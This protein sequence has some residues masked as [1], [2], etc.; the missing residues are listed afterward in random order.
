MPA[1]GSLNAD[2]S[3]SVRPA[4]DGP[5]HSNLQLLLIWSNHHAFGNEWSPQAQVDLGDVELFL[6][7]RRDI[8]WARGLEVGTA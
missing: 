3:R 7:P 5:T 4:S 6:A 2:Q 8:L 1:F